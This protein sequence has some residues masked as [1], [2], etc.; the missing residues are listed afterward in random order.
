VRSC[1]VIAAAVVLLSLG[2]AAGYGWYF[3]DKAE[4][5]CA[6]MDRLGTLPLVAQPGTRWVYGYS[7]DVLGCVVE[8]V[9]GEPLDRFFQDRIFGPLGMRDTRFYVEPRDTARLT[10]VY[11]VGADGRLVRA[12]DGPL[13][14]GDYVTGP[15][16]SFSGGAGLVSTARDYARFLQMLDNGGVLDG[17]RVLG[18]RTVTL[19]T[20]GQ[21][22][23]LYGAPGLGFSLG[24]QVLEDP[25]RAGRYG[26]PGVFSWG[27]A[28]ATNYWVDPAD[29]LVGVIMTQMLPGGDRGLSDR[30]TSLVYQAI[31]A[32]AS[33]TR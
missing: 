4:P 6:T 2:P 19:M 26:S 21:V 16:M 11:S 10:A 14:Q 30:F 13:G 20:R 28:Y 31:V 5:I 9:S 8:R 17:V 1:R 18:P 24:F 25:G 33:A 3:A 12:P 7:L 23:S 32:P 29:D 15:R 27:G 22:D